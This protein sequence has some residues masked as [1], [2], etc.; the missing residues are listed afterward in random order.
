MESFV[1]FLLRYI[2]NYIYVCVCVCLHA[3]VYIGALGGQKKALN[4]LELESQESPLTWKL[5][6]E[7]MFSVRPVCYL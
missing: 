1:F 2:L 6:A 5:S 4:F 7:V 3:C